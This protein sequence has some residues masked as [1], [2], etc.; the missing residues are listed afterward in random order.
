MALRQLTLFLEDEEVDALEREAAEQG[1]A[2]VSAHIR[3]IL[4]C[5]RIKLEDNE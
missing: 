3:W 4:A 1:R 5:R 2:G